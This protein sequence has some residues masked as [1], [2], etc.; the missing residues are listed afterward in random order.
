LITIVNNDVNDRS[1][2]I[3][4]DSFANSMIPFLVKHYNRIDIVDPRY[5][6]KSISKYVKENNIDDI[7]IIYNLATLSTDRN[8]ESIR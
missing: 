5:Y 1:L 2:L 4:K 6:K 7:L 3:I 8:I